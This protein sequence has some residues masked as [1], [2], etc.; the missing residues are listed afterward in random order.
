M[1]NRIRIMEVAVLIAIHLLVLLVVEEDLVRGVPVI[2]KAAGAGGLV[3]IDG[4]P[5]NGAQLVRSPSPQLTDG[6]KIKIAAAG[7]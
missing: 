3:E 5:G 2:V 4:G 7:N 6:M 1:D